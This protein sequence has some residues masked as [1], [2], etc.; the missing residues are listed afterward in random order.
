MS[1]LS[2]AR[3]RHLELLASVE[4]NT[5]RLLPLLN[6]LETPEAPDRVA[7]L[8]DLLRLILDMQQRTAMALKD[9]AD[10]IDRLSR[11]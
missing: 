3:P 7:Q 1:D 11:R 6:L 2:E 4:H 10:K 9:V 8:L 5:T